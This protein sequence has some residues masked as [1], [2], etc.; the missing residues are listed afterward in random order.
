MYIAIKLNDMKANELRVG[1]YVKLTK[2][3]KEDFSNVIGEKIN[4][5]F[6]VTFFNPDGVDFDGYDFTFE[7]LEPIPLTEYIFKDIDG[8]EKA[9]YDDDIKDYYLIKRCGFFDIIYEDD[10]NIYIDFGDTLK[11]V[12]YLHQLQ[13]L[14]FALTSKELTIK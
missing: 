10:D 6:S 4:N 13:N 2:E 1:N 3:A 11:K 12:K 7:E 14:Y 5:Y 9:P 8:V